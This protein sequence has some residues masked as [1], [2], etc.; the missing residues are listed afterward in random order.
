MAGAGGGAGMVG[1]RGEDE[2]PGLEAGPAGSLWD[3][4]AGR[5][6]QTQCAFQ[7]GCAHPA[8]GT[9]GRQ[10]VKLLRRRRCY[11]GLRGFTA[12][13][14]ELREIIRSE[15]ARAKGTPRTESWCLDGAHE[16][17]AQPRN[18]GPRCGPAWHKRD[19]VCHPLLPKLLFQTHPKSILTAAH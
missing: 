4:A 2:F 16:L 3:L 9:V 13:Q 7:P 14:G 15:G 6:P 10:A 17:Q 8:G 1:P 19:T 5:G 12:L 11:L 18:P